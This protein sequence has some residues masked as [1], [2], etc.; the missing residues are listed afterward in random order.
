MS[1][2]ENEAN[3]NSNSGRSALLRDK[4][5]LT[6]W[7]KG[8]QVKASAAKYRCW[9]ASLGDITNQEVK[10]VV[11][12]KWKKKH[13]SA[14]REPSIHEQKDQLEDD[15]SALV[16]LIYE[17]LHPD[18]QQHIEGDALMDP[19][20]MWRQINDHFGKTEDLDAQMRLQ[21]EMGESS[22]EGKTVE[23]YITMM[24]TYR[25]S[26]MNVGGALSNKQFILY[27][28]NGLGGGEVTLLECKVVT[29]RQA[30]REQQLECQRGSIQA[31]CRRSHPGARAGQ[32]G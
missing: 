15:K 13:P 11:I 24:K 4:A 10:A 30:G 17:R 1:V 16:D 18:V 23:A 31:A 22:K 8:I 21:T 14:E 12:K 9:H 3:S 5:Q 26:Y 29:H 20:V 7:Q 27:I 25:T 32:A 2:E 6:N 28:L 19:V